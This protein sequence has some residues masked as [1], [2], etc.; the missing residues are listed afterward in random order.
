VNL[1]HT[2]GHPKPHKKAELLRAMTKET[3]K[4]NSELVGRRRAERKATDSSL[5][6]A[7][8]EGALSVQRGSHRKGGVDF[9]GKR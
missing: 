1:V 3:G 2:S 4:G 6:Y 5:L 9:R 7:A 8:R